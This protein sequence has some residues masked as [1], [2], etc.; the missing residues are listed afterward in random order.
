MSVITGDAVPFVRDMGESE[1]VCECMKVLRQLFKEQVSKLAPRFRP[2]SF[3]R[4]KVALWC[5]ALP[6]CLAP[7]MKALFIIQSYKRCSVDRRTG[8]HY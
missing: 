8:E 7:A 2:G 4:I 5:S 6:W 3:A 1:V